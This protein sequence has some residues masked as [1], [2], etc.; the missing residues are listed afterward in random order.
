MNIKVIELLLIFLLM[1]NQ[2]LSYRD[3]RFPTAYLTRTFCLMAEF[4]NEFLIFTHL[5]FLKILQF[6][7]SIKLQT[8]ARQLLGL[9]SLLLCFLIIHCIYAFILILLCV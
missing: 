4:T 7:C 8:E 1:Q 9:L 2:D 5:P 3:Q 6:S